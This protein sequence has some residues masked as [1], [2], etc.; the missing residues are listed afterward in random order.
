VGFAGGEGDGQY[1]TVVINPATGAEVIEWE[2]PR[3]SSLSSL[4]A[5][6]GLAAYSAVV[7]YPTSGAELVEWVAQRLRNND[8][9]APAGAIDESQ[10]STI[11]VNPATGQAEVVEYS[12]PRLSS[13]GIVKKYSSVVINPDTGRAETVEWRAAQAK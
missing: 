5:V 9:A 12:A 10:Y 11:L 3:V 2:A 6:E 8:T 1:S 7:V 13:D 4:P